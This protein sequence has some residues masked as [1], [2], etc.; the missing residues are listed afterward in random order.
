MQHEALSLRGL[1]AAKALDDVTPLAFDIQAEAAGRVLLLRPIGGPRGT[2]IA[3]VVARAA[4]LAP[5]R[6]GLDGVHERGGAAVDDG[7]VGAGL[8]RRRGGT[9]AR[10]WARAC[11]RQ[12]ARRVGRGPALGRLFLEL[13]R[14]GP[15][16]LAR[17]RRGGGRVGA[18]GRGRRV[19]NRSKL[20]HDEP[21]GGGL[22]GG[23]LAGAGAVGGMFGCG[24]LGRGGARGAAGTRGGRAE[25]DERVRAR[26]GGAVGDGGR[27][28]ALGALLAQAG[29]G[30][31][32]GAREHAARREA[33]A[34]HGGG[35][36]RAPA[37]HRERIYARAPRQGREKVA[38]G[39]FRCARR[40]AT[41]RRD[42]VRRPSVEVWECMPRQPRSAAF[43]KRSGVPAPRRHCWLHRPK[44]W[45]FTC[46]KYR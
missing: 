33:A 31:A 38:R 3:G 28:K 12:A 1:H 11:H 42:D 2:A 27:S 34:A 19:A 45:P 8:R 18:G 5:Q 20:G 22:A 36:G 41:R 26:L 15:P 30:G 46:H 9:R 29:D 37:R 6:H 40:S 10:A 21:A 43:S 32:L 35:G 16:R 4:E 39:R 13:V 14:R 23:G 7:Q 44:I 17:H 24:G 25:G